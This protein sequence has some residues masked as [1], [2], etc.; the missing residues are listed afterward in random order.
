MQRLFQVQ[1]S[2]ISCFEDQFVALIIGSIAFANMGIAMLEPSLPLWMMETMN[3]PKWQQGLV[4]T[5]VSCSV[6]TSAVTVWLVSSTVRKLW[7]M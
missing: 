4:T 6:I 5:I 7:L 2:L 1:S 3:A